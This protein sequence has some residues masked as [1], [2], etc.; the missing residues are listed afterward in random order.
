[1]MPRPR[2]SR[3]L[4]AL[5][6]PSAL[7]AQGGTGPMAPHTRVPPTLPFNPATQAGEAPLYPGP[8]YQVGPGPVGMV[9]GDFNSDG[10]PDL[11]TLDTGFPPASGDL[12]FLFG[13]GDGTFS[14]A[15]T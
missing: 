8:A 15:T 14:P 11:A 13:A 5:I 12:S 10:H 2:R 6:L 7:A 1:M 9:T 3:L 4:L